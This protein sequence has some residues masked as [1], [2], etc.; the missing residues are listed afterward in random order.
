MKDVA[1]MKDQLM[2]YWD[3]DHDGR[4]DQNELK[5]LLIQQNRM[6]A[7]QSG[8][9]DEAATSSQHLGAGAGLSQHRS[10]TPS[11]A[12]PVAAH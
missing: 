9:E 11:P 4:V 2:K 3:I 1:F 5:M 12:P 7:E 8:W 10:R 6:A